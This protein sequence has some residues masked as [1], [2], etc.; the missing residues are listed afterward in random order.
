LNFLMLAGRI[1]QLNFDKG[2]GFI[3]PDGG[4]ADVFFHH[5]VVVGRQFTS[6]KPGQQVQYVVDEAADRPRAARVE[7]ASTAAQRPPARSRPPAIECLRGF[8]TKLYHEPPHGFISADSGG[9][10][11]RFEPPA[12]TG[13]KRFRDLRVGDYVEFSVQGDTKGTKHPAAEYVREIERTHE[14]P[15]THLARHP[16]AR[17]KKPTWRSD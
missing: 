8:V 10:E 3:R 17:R 15:R 5:S 14:F 11:I 4:A 9:T 16:R 7:L 1:Q 13:K 12:V 2:F 6:L